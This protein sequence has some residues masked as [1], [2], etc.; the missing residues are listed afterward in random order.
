MSTNFADIFYV[1]DQNFIENSLF[2]F[3]ANTCILFIE[4]TILSRRE[5]RAFYVK[6]FPCDRLFG[7]SYH[8]HPRPLGLRFLR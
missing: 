2:P 8:Q 3:C 7:H 4:G 1:R 6:T 5:R